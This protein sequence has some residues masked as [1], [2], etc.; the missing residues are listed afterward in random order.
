MR[1]LGEPYGAVAELP[2][3]NELPT[4]NDEQWKLVE[5]T[6][7][8]AVDGYIGKPETQAS[9][10]L[11]FIEQT[12]PALVAAERIKNVV[13]HTPLQYAPGLSARVGNHVTMKRE[14]LQSVHSFKIRGAANRMLQMT[15]A[16]RA[17]GVIT[18]SAGNHAQGVARM[19]QRLGIPATIIMPVTTPLVKIEAVKSYGAN[20]VLEGD[21]YSEA[22]VVR[23][24]LQEQTGATFIHA[25]D[26]DAVIAGQGTVGLEIMKSEPNTDYIF[27]PIGGGGLAAGVIQAAK[28]VNPDVKIIGVQYEGSD[29]MAQ[30]V[31]RGEKVTLDQVGRYSD[32]TAVAT[33][34]S[35]SFDIVKTGI[36]EIIT[37]SEDE[38]ILAT[39]DFYNET[40]NYLEPAGAL[41]IAGMKQ[42]CD[43]PNAPKNKLMTVVCSGGNLAP[44]KISYTI[45]RA[46]ILEGRRALLSIA[47]PEEPGALRKLCRVLGPH[48]INQFRYA[49]DDARTGEI[50]IELNLADSSDKAAVLDLLST[51]A[52]EYVDHMNDPVA[53]RHASHMVGGPSSLPA[54]EETTFEITFPERAGALL[55]F[56]DTVGDTWNITRFDYVGDNSETGNV[57]IS[58]HTP[59]P[60]DAE[61]LRERLERTGYLHQ[62]TQPGRLSKFA[63]SQLVNHMLG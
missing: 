48:N 16:E 54:G 27:V 36:D 61:Q 28:S 32:G 37:V 9:V 2:I 52:Y 23:S 20:I 51:G 17:A 35:K 25:F 3:V 33:V 39:N 50:L 22:E 60:N 57:L 24:A 45:E 21:N 56:L 44:E 59:Q 11:E 47:L 43:R 58:Y 46:A 26:D 8:S 29:A 6:C 63:G 42:F 30:S 38:I 7:S 34:G 62:Q 14:D 53:L 40:R 4:L 41:A 1:M 13:E 5:D 18:T 55:K 19:A 49:Y 15:D 12:W 31:M 10:V